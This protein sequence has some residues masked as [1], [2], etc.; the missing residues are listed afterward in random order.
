MDGIAMDKSKSVL[1]TISEIEDSIDNAQ[2]KSVG[3][4]DYEAALKQYERAKQDL[5]SLKVSTKEIECERNRVL[6]YCLMRINDVLDRLERNDTPIDRAKESLRLAESSGNL[7]QILRSKMALGIAHLNQGELK[8]AEKHFGEIIIQTRNEEDN[9]DIIQIYG[10]TLIVRVNILL[11]K[12]LY[13]QAEE[14]ALKALGVLRRIKN[15]AGLRTASSL[16]SKTYQSI[17]DSEKAR[18]YQ[19]EAEKY[20]KLAIEY[21]Q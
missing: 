16:L 6:S 17:G 5:E 3:D 11:G 15:Y 18:F 1:A 8:T 2:W 7:V 9:H 13:N 10:W 12:S 4:E 21:R 19:D 14:L 20:A